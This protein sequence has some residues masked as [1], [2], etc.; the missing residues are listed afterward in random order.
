MIKQRGSNRMRWILIGGVLLFLAVIIFPRPSNRL[1]LE[2]SQVFRMAEDGQVAEIQVRGDKLK[3][4]G[5]DGQTFSSRKESSVSLLE[6]LT[7]R[8]IATGG[9][10]IK[11]VVKEERRSL[12]GIVLS[13]LPLI[14]IGGLIFWMMSRARGGMGQIMQIGKSKARLLV[15]KPSVTFDDV[16]G[17]DE[18]KQELAEIVEFLKTPEK[19]AKLGAKI[20]RGVLLIGPPGTGKTLLGRAVAGEAGVSFFSIS[21]SEFVEMFVG[22]GASRVRD[23]FDRAK[24]SQP[25][26]VFIDDGVYQIKKGQDT[27]ALGMKNFSATY[28]VVEMEKQDAEEDADI[29][30]VWRIIV[31]RESLEARGLD[32]GDLI[33]GVEVMEADALSALMD[34]QDVVLS[35]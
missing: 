30:M 3:V 16:A 11:I 15:D 34:A 28:R 8:G 1:E 18:A 14:I 4:T 20:P 10:G 2:I 35:G 26:I 17:V 9:D 29:D 33:V 23:L 31:E 7:E 13:L 19:F 12:F 32:V 21:G 27:K 5:T 22:V 25:A 6:L 24:A